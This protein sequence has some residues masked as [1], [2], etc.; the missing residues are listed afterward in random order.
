MTRRTS[1]GSGP[2]RPAVPILLRRRGRRGGAVGA[3]QE[4][5]DPLHVR[6]AVVRVEHRA[7]HPHRVAEEVAL[8][9]RLAR[10]ERAQGDVP[11]EPEQLDA[12]DRVRA[13]RL[14]VPPDGVRLRPPEVALRRDGHE[15]GRAELLQDLHQARVHPRVHVSRGVHA[16]CMIPHR[17]TWASTSLVRRNAR[18]ASRSTMISAIFSCTCWNGSI[19]MAS[20]MSEAT[21]ST[22]S[23]LATFLVT[24]WCAICATAP[25]AANARLHLSTSHSRNT[26]SHGTS[27]SSKITTA[28][29]SSNLAARG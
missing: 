19:A 15:P 8:V 21:P 3:L 24:T 16:G 2:A 10:P 6:P 14:I 27:T 23:V 28:S 26:R 1:V 22:N 17:L 11:R 9:Q 25:V 12:A 20:T 4:L 29:I 7:R 18:I 5:P 13:R